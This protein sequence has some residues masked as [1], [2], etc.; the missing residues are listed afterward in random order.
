MNKED[1]PEVKPDKFK[2]LYIGIGIFMTG[3]IILAGAATLAGI[4]F[5]VFLWFAG[6]FAYQRMGHISQWKQSNLPLKDYLILQNDNKNGSTK[7]LISTGSS[8]DG[9]YDTGLSSKEGTQW[10]AF[11]E[12]FEIESNSFDIIKPLSR[13]KRKPKN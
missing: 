9:D 13:K 10:E 7:T 6:I 12:Q 4:F 8:L 11:V 1:N 2:F 3:A 5:L